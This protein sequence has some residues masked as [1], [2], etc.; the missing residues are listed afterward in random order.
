MT[1]SIKE[2][3]TEYD[4]ITMNYYSIPKNKVSLFNNLLK[5]LFA[6]MLLAF[7]VGCSSNDYYEIFA[8]IQ[9][10][11]TDY[12]TGALLENASVTLSPSGLSRQTDASG[13]YSFSD[14]D[15]QQY[16]VTVQKSGYQPN[17]KTVTA[18]SGETLQ[19]DV[20]LNRI[21]KE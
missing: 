10:V 12:E 17:R 16:T 11:V 14:L 9:G 20:Q 2:L 7:A 6:V 19:V 5:C 18:V 3:K 1:I 13:Q 8:K 15:V 4:K 21:P